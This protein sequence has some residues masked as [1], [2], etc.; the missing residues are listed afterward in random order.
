VSVWSLAASVRRWCKLNA[1]PEMK[2]R[3]IKIGLPHE[4]IQ[5]FMRA[6]CRSPYELAY[7]ACLHYT[8]THTHTHTSPPT[9]CPPLPCM[10]ALETWHHT[11]LLAHANTHRHFMHRYVMHRYVMHRYVLHRYV[12][13]RYVMHRYVLH[14]YVLHR[15]VLHRYVLHRYVLH[16][17]HAHVS[18]CRDPRAAA[19]SVA[20]HLCCDNECTRHHTSPVTMNPIECDDEYC[21]DE[22]VL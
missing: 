20:P 19:L 8:Y 9:A 15:Y 5:V 13:H 3:M 1:C 10:H 22:F 17:M 16:T 2:L 4:S 11:F 18:S 21:Q 6:S 7:R 12:M 14:R